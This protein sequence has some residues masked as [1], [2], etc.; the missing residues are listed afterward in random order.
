MTKISVYM[1]TPLYGPLGAPLQ[2]PVAA[3]APVPI[4]LKLPMMLARWSGL[5]MKAVLIWLT[6]SPGG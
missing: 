3:Q 4:W 2:G 5:F 6:L 1:M